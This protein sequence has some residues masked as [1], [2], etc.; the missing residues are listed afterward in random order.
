MNIKDSFVNSVQTIWTH[1][2]RS[3]L[4]LL[5]IVIGVFAVVT[6]FSSIHGMKALIATQ[7]ERMGWNNSMM[8][9]ASDGSRQMN[10]RWLR[11]RWVRR[12]PKPIDFDDYL[13]L[14]NELNAKHIYGT[15][16]SWQRWRNNDKE[17]WIKLTGT[18]NDFFTSKTYPLRE[19]RYFNQFETMNAAKVCILGHHFANDNFPGID[20]LGETITI[21]ALR[22]RV[23]G[24]LNRD[25]VNENQ[26]DF[27]RWERKRDLDGVYMPLST[28]SKYF[29]SDK[30]IDLIYLQAHDQASYQQLR[31][32]ARQLLLAKHKMAHDFDF[33][34][35]GA[36]V[37][38]ISDEIQ[39]MLKKWNITL[40]AIASISLIVGGI[41]L[42]STLLISINERMMEIGVRKSIGATEKDIFSHFLLEALFLSIFGAIIG[43][44]FSLL[45]ITIGSAALKIA[46]PLPVAGIFLGLGFAVVIGLISGVYPA[47]KAARI[48]PIKAIYYME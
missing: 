28:A 47:W 48:D 27:N 16:D 23:I 19:G 5:G 4:T 2:M 14:K 9:Y 25:V 32:R 10:Q 22:L 13:L 20:M 11:F 29:R 37:T 7:M 3:S 30:A 24:I 33:S 43:I 44:I 34:D 12:Q 45:L 35:L 6:M 26:M 41:G 18:T 39:G 38:K 46:L 31:T 17:K 1:K 36:M 42:F 21:G 40:S 15:I 8:I